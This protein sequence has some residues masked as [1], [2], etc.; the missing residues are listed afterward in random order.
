MN[1]PVRNMFQAY[2]QRF[3]AAN[4]VIKPASHIQ[5]VNTSATFSAVSEWVE[6]YAPLDT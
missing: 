1:A 5:N 2:L 3:Y 4:I 6:F